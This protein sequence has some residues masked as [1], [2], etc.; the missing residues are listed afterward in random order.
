MDFGDSADKAVHERMVK[1]VESM[2]DLHQQLAS[3]KSAAQKTLT[4]HQI[5]ATDAKI[6]GLVYD[7]YRLT[8]EEIAIVEKAT[9]SANPL[10]AQK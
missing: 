2:L 6:D 5:D 8:A 4:Q 9:A 1:L 3:A 7:L 10:S